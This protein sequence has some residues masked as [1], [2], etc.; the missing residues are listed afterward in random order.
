[1]ESQPLSLSRPC[2]LLIDDANKDK[3]ASGSVPE[4]GADI[5]AVLF[6]AGKCPSLGRDS[7]LCCRKSKNT[8]PAA[9]K[10][11]GKPFRLSDSHSLPEFLSVAYRSFSLEE[12]I[13]MSD[14][15]LDLLCI[16]II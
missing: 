5:P 13:N 16:S 7:M 1:M 3:G 15:E 9:S 11:V 2:L 10:S 6:L 8:F 12:L 14:A 4:G